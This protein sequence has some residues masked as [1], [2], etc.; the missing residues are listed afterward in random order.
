MVVLLL[1]L[2]RAGDTWTEVAPGVRQLLRTTSDPLRIFAIEADLCG[3]GVSLRAT[4][5]SERADQVSDF[6]E[7]VGATAAINGDFFSYDDYST[8]GLAVGQGEQWCSDNTSEGFIAGGRD[9]SWISPPSEDWDELAVWMEQAVG[10]R[11]QLVV[12]GVAQSGLDSPS[13]CE[14]LNPR[15]AVGLSRDRQTLYML[16]VDGRSSASEGVTCDWLADTMVE[17]GAY[18]ALNLD[19]GGSSTLWTDVSGVVNDPSD[20]SERVVANHLA[21]IV[22][23]SEPAQSCDWWQDDLLLSAHALDPGPTDVD[24]DG[25]GDVCA[26]SSKDFRCVTGSGATWTLPDLSNDAGF[27]EE[28]AY[29]TLRSG[30]ID[31]DGLADFCARGAEGVR[32]FRS[33]GS[34]F[35]AAIEGPELSDAVGWG[36]I[37]YFSTL[38]LA[39]ITGDGRDDLCAR[40]S[41]GLWCWPSTGTGFGDRI[42]GPSWSDSSGWD[43]PYYYG[44]IRLGDLDGD[45]K[46]D[47]CAR[48]AAGMSCYLSDGDGF[49]AAIGGPAWTNDL[50]WNAV[51][52]WSTIRL[53]DL[54]GD[55]RAELCGRGEGGF[56]CY[57]W[58]GTAWLAALSFADVADDNGWWDHSNYATFQLGD[59]DGDGDK[60]FCARADAGTYCWIY[61]DG[62]LGTRW[63]G[64]ALSDDGS[65]DHWRYYSTIRLADATGD[66]MADLCA[67]YGAGWRCHASTGSGFGEAVAGP[68]WSDELGWDDM[69]YYSTIR[70]GGSRVVASDGDS[71]SVDNDSDGNEAA[72]ATR[73]PGAGSGCGC[74]GAAAWWLL[75]L[76]GLRRWTLHRGHGIL[77]R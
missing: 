71:G 27:G 62:A 3:D 6:A 73:T 50:G 2:A 34:G 21:L 45:K 15:T 76:V 14:D 41:A 22:S 19:G 38:R 47:A 25:T 30:D 51:M 24:G 57:R 20:G 67:R 54:D 29:S 32:C 35:D 28:S 75:P 26:R 66:G 11:P 65:W 39:D 72:A 59:V 43:E 18:T 33:N 8:S 46:A 37:R 55:G 49:P 42:D 9:H 68:E 16:V 31:G 23:G 63:D 12:D 58:D 5:S 17:L 60:D 36:D 1:S 52:Y 4:R 56:E 61:A 7:S 44:T 40:A 70:L 13:H 53:D 77:R 48:A 74:E 69:K 10:G 64:P